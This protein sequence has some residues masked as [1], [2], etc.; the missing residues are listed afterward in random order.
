MNNLQLPLNGETQHI[1]PN[2]CCVPIQ[3]LT[4]CC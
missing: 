4:V 2:V 1:I 3:M